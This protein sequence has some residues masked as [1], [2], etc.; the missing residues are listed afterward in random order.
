MDSFSAH[1]DG[2]EQT[3]ALH[4][5]AKVD[6]EFPGEERHIS[7]DDEDGP[8]RGSSQSGFEARERPLLSG[9]GVRDAPRSGEVHVLSGVSHHDDFREKAAKDMICPFEER[10]TAHFEKEFVAAWKPAAA[11]SGQDDAGDFV[12]DA[13]G[14]ARVFVGVFEERTL[15]LK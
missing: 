1:R 7:G 9:T 5:F 11:S 12:A 2:G 15:P 6:G 14:T 10:R 4:S 13:Q 8:V 3:F